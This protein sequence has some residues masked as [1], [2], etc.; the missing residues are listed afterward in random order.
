MAAGEIFFLLEQELEKI[1]LYYEEKK[2]TTIIVIY[3]SVLFLLDQYF[4]L[5]VIN[6]PSAS[7]LP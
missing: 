7:I 1:F 2:K 6:S 3:F 5:I 4:P